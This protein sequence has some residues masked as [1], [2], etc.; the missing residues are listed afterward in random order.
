MPDTTH[1]ASERTGEAL[2]RTPRALRYRLETGSLSEA[3]LRVAAYCGGEAA[4]VVFG[5]HHIPN[6]AWEW[7]DEVSGGSSDT[8]SSEHWLLGL[9]TKGAGLDCGLSE[10]RC[11]V[12]QGTGDH[13]HALREPGVG[14]FRYVGPVTCVCQGTSTRT[15]PRN[16]SAYLLQRAAVVAARLALP[17]WLNWI[18]ASPQV[19]Q[20]VPKGGTQGIFAI[21]A[22]QA[23]LEADTLATREAWSKCW[24]TDRFVPWLWHNASGRVAT[25][26]AA[27]RLMGEGCRHKYCDDACFVLCCKCR[28][29]GRIGGET[30]VCETI[31]ADLAEWALA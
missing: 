19:A 28:G 7:A 23:N 15:V 31:C 21:D 8:W 25:I 1:R 29:T 5:K 6:V 26:L 12:C 24:H 13:A 10:V 18:A 17:R 2:P 14:G 11:E 30:V 27:A 3:R 4:R 9:G 16:G 20:G 22:A